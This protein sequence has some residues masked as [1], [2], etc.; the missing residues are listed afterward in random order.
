[1]VA[2]VTSV[3]DRHWLAADLKVGDRVQLTPHGARLLAPQLGNRYGVIVGDRDT[4]WRVQ[5][6]TTKTPKEIWKPYIEPE[7]P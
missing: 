6:D 5:W 2:A 7:A 4:C 3:A 1:M